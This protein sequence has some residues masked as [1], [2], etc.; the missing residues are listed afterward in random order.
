[1]KYKLVIFDFDGTLANTFPW[2]LDN[3]DQVADKFKLDRIDRN[4]MD[5]IRSFDLRKLMKYYDV[6]PWKLA[7]MT[8]YVRKRLG[9][10]IQQ[11]SLF[12]GIDQLLE[13][14]S[15]QGTKL[16]VVSSNSYDNVRQ[17]LGPINAA[18][19]DYYECGVSVFGKPTK[20][21]KILHK[22]KV[23]PA[24]VISIGDEIRDIQAA[25]HVHIASG[26][27]AWGFTNVD[28]LKAQSPHELFASI[29]EIA[30][31]IS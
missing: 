10:D 1:M 26:A 13:Y 5:A 30:E 16:A 31:K 2:V 19:I 8:R 18:L 15:E 23:D 7:L 14:L 9:E 29:D 21:R 3:M 12:E 6:S 22:S 4:E 11:V 17:V 20:F 27:V 25:K 28:A 24:D